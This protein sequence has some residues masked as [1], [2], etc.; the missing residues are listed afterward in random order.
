[1]SIIIIGGYEHINF[2]R[3]KVKNKYLKHLENNVFP[4]KKNIQAGLSCIYFSINFLIKNQ[5]IKC[6]LLLLHSQPYLAPALTILFV[7]I[8]NKRF[9]MGEVA[10][11]AY[12]DF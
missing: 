12:T 3:L 11:I 6:V 4:S 10:F 1:M 7:R 9:S 8:Y 2:A 5:L